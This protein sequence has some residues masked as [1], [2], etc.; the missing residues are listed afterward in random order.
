[1][2]RWWM[3]YNQYTLEV[4]RQGLCDNLDSELDSNHWA[5]SQVETTPKW[6]WV[7]L[8]CIEASSVWCLCCHTP[9]SVFPALIGNRFLQH[10]FLLL[11]FFCFVSYSGLPLSHHLDQLFPLY[12][13]SF[14]WIHSHS[15]NTSFFP[16][17][18]L[19]QLT[20]DAQVCCPLPPSCP[21]QDSVESLALCWD[22]CSV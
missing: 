6:P 5:L 14:S 4:A 1:M 19:V 9:N 13:V 20:P 11:C 8:A 10:Y 17:I 7:S 3:N 2:K 16:S 22:M 15:F 21:N 12:L 18:P